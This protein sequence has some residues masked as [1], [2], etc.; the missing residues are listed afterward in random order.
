MLTASTTTLFRGRR[1]AV[2]Y[3]SDSFDPCGT[4]HINAEVGP[5]VQMVTLVVSENEVTRLRAQGQGKIKI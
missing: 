4:S 3:V 1:E 5:T 2:L